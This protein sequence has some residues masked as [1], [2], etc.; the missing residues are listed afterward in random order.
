MVFGGSAEVA[1]E[2]LDRMLGTSPQRGAAR[3]WRMQG[4]VFG[5]QDLRGDVGVHSDDRLSVIL[6]GR[7]DGGG[8][9]LSLLR[10][11]ESTQQQC[12]ILHQCRVRLPTRWWEQLDGE[13]SLALVDHTADE[14]WFITG[15]SGAFPLFWSS[16]KDAGFLV[17]TEMRQLQAGLGYR[18][19]MAAESLVE[20]MCF[21]GSMRDPATTLYPQARRFV[22]GRVFRLGGGGNTPRDLGR[23]WHYPTVP[24]EQSRDSLIDQ[25]LAVLREAV[26]A[27][28]KHPGAHVLAT[29]S[30]MDSGTL[31][32]LVRELQ[33]GQAENPCRS[34]SMIFPGLPNDESVGLGYLHGH[35]QSVGC[36]YNASEFR[37]SDF[38]AETL[39][40]LDGL[41]A[42]G[43]S[44]QMLLLGRAIRESGY[45]TLITGIAGDV[46]FMPSNTY[47]A[48]MWREGHPF[49]ALAMA[50]R[51]H[52]NSGATTSLKSRL[53]H[54]VDRV[55]L[56][57][58][59]KLRQRL[60]PERPP[61]W[62]NSRW[63][64]LFSDVIQHIYSHYRERTFREGD[65][66]YK[67]RLVES[68]NIM[69]VFEQLCSAN[70]IQPLA[71]MMARPVIEF[72]G[73]VDPRVLG[74]NMPKA[75]MREMMRGRLPDEITRNPQNVVQDSLVEVDRLLL[76]QLGDPREWVL[77]EAELLS[78]KV[79]TIWSDA[80][81]AGNV[82]VY[83]PRLAG[84]EILAR[85]QGLLSE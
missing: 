36:Y 77:A 81:K 54:M 58:P 29:S 68:G 82:P 85:R 64:A 37:L 4:L 44:F 15:M 35:L 79:Y 25:G 74:G 72:T 13:F 78:P 55:L 27:T 16:D 47:L 69:E 38:Q 31:W 57:R 63:H 28:L 33:A 20:H 40:H 46:W 42:A 24:V 49:Q 14:A 21:L 76:E 62:L 50:W 61:I 83:W 9:F 53:R 43:S 32:A 73:C 34:Y 67:H 51:F 17:A 11:A 7:I 60:R 71:P 3:T 6:C 59:G 45:D 66:W 48:D 84:A 80:L 26:A 56:P 18:L 19:G 65:L 22:P 8:E 1:G 52:D 10:N 2:R 75:F 12:E 5:I 39:A 30:G 41:P 70:G 23:F